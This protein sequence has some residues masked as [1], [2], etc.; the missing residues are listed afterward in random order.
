MAP[1]HGQAHV[2][3]ERRGQCGRGRDEFAWLDARLLGLPCGAAP[4]R[5]VGD[6]W[7]DNGHVQVHVAA[8]CVCSRLV[9]PLRSL[10]P[11]HAAVT[12]AALVWFRLTC[13]RIAHHDR[14]P[15]NCFYF[16]IA[17]LTAP[18]P[19][20]S[21]QDQRR[22]L[23]SSPTPHCAATGQRDGSAPSKEGNGGHVGRRAP[24]AAALGIDSRY[25]HG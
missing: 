5:C 19:A 15:R 18:R 17:L 22:P 11:R 16:S 3:G 6:G 1:Q 21:F 10:A 13:S 23:E 20:L 25:R 24:R 9:I 2:S 12:R 7:L 8:C 4:A 14:I